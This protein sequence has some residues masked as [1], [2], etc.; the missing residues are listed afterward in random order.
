M[1]VGGGPFRER[2]RERCRPLARHMMDHMQHERDPEVPAVVH[3][4]PADD[5]VRAWWVEN[6]RSL[7]VD[8]WRRQGGRPT[9]LGVTTR[10]A[11]AEIEYA[12]EH[13]IEPRVGVP[14]HGTSKAPAAE[15]E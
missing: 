6:Y 9:A 10:W 3:V 12:R 13:G 8:A 1:V 2:S 5:P 4:V 15:P 11:C 7:V 14:P